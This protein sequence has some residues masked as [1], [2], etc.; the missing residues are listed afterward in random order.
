MSENLNLILFIFAMALAT[1]VTRVAPF[2][3]PEDI[4]SSSLAQKANR[5]LPTAILTLLV[6]YSIKDT[7]FERISDGLP[8][9]ISIC[10]ALGIHLWKRNALLSIFSGTT[11]YMIFKQLIFKL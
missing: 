1:L 4:T 6:I 3:L 2:L 10:L 5:I 11:L 7:P 8:E 9:I